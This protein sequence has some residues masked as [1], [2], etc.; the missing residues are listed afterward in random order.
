[1]GH[2]MRLQ[3]QA[4]GSGTVYAALTGQHSQV[5][6]FSTSTTERKGHRE[7]AAAAGIGFSP[8]GVDISIIR[9]TEPRANEPGANQITNLTGSG[10][11][12]S[13]GEADVAALT[14]PGTGN[15]AFPSYGP[16]GSEVRFE[17]FV[18]L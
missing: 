16:D 12:V 13:P 1:M 10:S 8:E 15:N 11:R 5:T 9:I 14:R 3:L 6:A 7:V 4:V 2:R 17:P 18:V